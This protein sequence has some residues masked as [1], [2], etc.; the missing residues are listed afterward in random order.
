[1]SLCQYAAHCV[2]Q[3][4]C[5]SR[6]VELLTNQPAGKGPCSKLRMPA[7]SRLQRVHNVGEALKELE[8]R[9]DAPLPITIDARSIVD[10]HR[11]KTLALLWHLILQFQL[12]SVL[13]VERLREEV[14]HLEDSLNYRVQ[15][16]DRSALRGFAFVAECKQ[17]ELKAADQELDDSFIRERGQEWASADK[18]KLLLA[19]TRLV[20]AH[21]GV[22]VRPSLSDWQQPYQFLLHAG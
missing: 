9:E 16:G 1:V 19:W 21:Y 22:E 10:G 15:I 8:K 17:R 11:E 3:H 18:I 7:Q 6:V 20:C 5:S 14:A 12:S 13:D 4:L 2:L